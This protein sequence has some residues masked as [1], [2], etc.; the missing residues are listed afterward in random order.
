MDN[1]DENVSQAQQLPRDVIT[2]LIILS[3][4]LLLLQYITLE[5]FKK[6]SPSKNYLTFSNFLEEVEKNH[7]VLNHTDYA[8][9]GLIVITSIILLLRWQSLSLFL[10][11]ILKSTL[12]TYVFLGFTILVCVRFYFA[13]GTSN[14]AADASAHTTYAWITSQIFSQGEWPIW[15]NYF[16]A[17]TPFL[18]FYGFLFFYFVGA[19]DQVVGNI[20]WS[21]KFVLTL[22]H[23][24]SSLGM[25]AFVSTALNSRRAGFIAGLAFALSFWHTQQI[26]IMGRLPLSL[27]YACLPW[28]FFFFEKLQSCKNQYLITLGG[29]L[30]LSLLVFTHPGYG[31]WA[32]VMFT[33]YTLSKLC[34]T[35]ATQTG[36]HLAKFGTQMIVGGVF[37]SSY[38]TLPMWVEKGYTGLRNGFQM[39]HYPDPSW[40]QLVNWSNHHFSILTNNAVINNWY[41]GYLGISLILLALL[42]Y[43]SFLLVQSPNKKTTAFA[44]GACVLLSLILV[45]GYRWSILQSLEVVK[46]LNSGRYLLFVV[47]F[48]STL[49]GSGFALLEERKK[50]NIKATRNWTVLIV[51]I[52]MLDLFPTT[53][54]FPFAPKENSGPSLIDLPTALY[55]TLQEG[56]SQS[57]MPSE[58]PNT[59]LFFD[60]KKTYQPLLISWLTIF[61]GMPN[62]DYIYTEATLAA[63]FYHTF[64]EHLSQQLQQP[65]TSHE[66]QEMDKHLLSGLALTNVSD[67]IFRKA[68]QHFKWTSSASTP[69]LISTQIKPVVIKE[70]PQHET[71]ALEIIKW[72]GDIDIEQNTCESI[73]LQHIKSTRIFNTKPSIKVLRH[74]VEIQKMT[75]VI[76]VSDSCFARLPYAYYPSLSVMRNKKSIAKMQTAGGFICIELPPGKHTIELVPSLSFL[77]KTLLGIEVVTL[78]AIFGLIYKSQRQGNSNT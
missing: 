38:L 48:M 41:G 47:F 5:K 1:E 20:F 27:F 26:I 18:Q 55:E 64:Y 7:V 16:C 67:V 52:I 46:A 69:I 58:I 75:M 68:N 30:M 71:P 11:V 42:G 63:V 19:V 72:M 40:Q 10:D 59:R 31:F 39:S 29:A 36:I 54:Q 62:I 56:I 21:I 74:K 12:K 8:L 33:V 65:N 60:D 66:L 14:W 32:I 22:G 25:C 53:F 23:V 24:I 77:R 51:L 78:L 44:A 43:M 70:N 61:L 17:G 13:L 34:I 3:G 37:F 28:P 45:F 6:L 76:E 49:V 57:S 35:H 73:I 2:S 50:G 15:N 4:G 9:I